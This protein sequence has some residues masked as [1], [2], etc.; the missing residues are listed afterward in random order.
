MTTFHP[1]SSMPSEDW[2]SFIGRI[3]SEGKGREGGGGER[4][5]IGVKKVN[6]GMSSEK[7]RIYISS[8]LLLING[9]VT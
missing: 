9:N 7:K 3:D 8:I 4:G 1:P 2:A 5:N 6:E